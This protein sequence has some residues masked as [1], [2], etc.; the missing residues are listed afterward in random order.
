MA[1]GLVMGVLALT[2]VSGL[3]QAQVYK[4]T[5]ADGSTEYAQTPCGANAKEVE[6][7]AG[8]TAS[9]DDGSDR[10]RQAIAQSN[11]LSS[12]AVAERNCVQRAEGDIL[13]PSNRRAAE[14]QQQIN[15]LNAQLAG[16]GTNLA[17]ATSQAGIRSQITGLQQSMAAD[18]SSAD[19]QVIA[20]RQN[21]ATI[22]RAREDEI[23]RPAETASGV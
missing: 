10:N 23:R 13:G 1:K 11:A 20:A 3:A 4:C 14:Y 21:C 12:A 8:P 17:G 22:R 16:A 15:A 19:A 5:R 18:R 9:T 7:R 2:L 6:V